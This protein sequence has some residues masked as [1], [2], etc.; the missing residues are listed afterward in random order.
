[1]AI[2]PFD[3]KTIDELQEL[4]KLSGNEKL[5]VSV[6]AE[7]TRKVSVDT[8][9]GYAASIL[10][11][12][13]MPVGYSGYGGGQCIIFVKEGQEIPVSQRTPGCFY[14]E[15]QRQT[16]IRTQI[17]IPTSVKVSTNLGLRRV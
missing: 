3:S 7:D 2:A 5:V 16:S 17:S 6:E 13:S 4:G 9:V 12:T 1:M 15:E 8:V 14:L 10:S 11:G